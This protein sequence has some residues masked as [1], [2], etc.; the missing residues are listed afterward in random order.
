MLTQYGLVKS[1]CNKF[2]NVRYFRGSSGSFHPKNSVG[3][4]EPIA[5]EVFLI[6]LANYCSVISGVCIVCV[7]FF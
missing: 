4:K 2:M 3:M 1:Y 7:K 6:S 5:S